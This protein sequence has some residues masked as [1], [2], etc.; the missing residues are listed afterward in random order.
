M[1]TIKNVEVWLSG[2][3]ITWVHGGEYGVGRKLEVE[4]NHEWM[5]LTASLSYEGRELS[6]KRLVLERAVDNIYFL[7]GEGMENAFKRTMVE[8]KDY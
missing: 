5:T 3:N 6:A 1:W 4:V 8:G 7:D 2:T